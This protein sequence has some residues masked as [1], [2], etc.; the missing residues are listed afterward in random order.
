MPEVYREGKV[1]VR[2]TKCGNCL[3]SKNRIVDGA[4]ARQLTADTRAE[5]GSSFICHR[6]MVSDEPEAICA[7]WFEHFG[8]EDPIFRLAIAMGIIERVE[9]DDE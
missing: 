1:H 5:D 7:E 2:A 3:Y 4:R 8:G 6:S 9:V